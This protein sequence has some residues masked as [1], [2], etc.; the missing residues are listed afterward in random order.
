M[1]QVEEGGGEIMGDWAH[2]EREGESE[3][4]SCS[5]TLPSHKEKRSDEP[6]QISW[7]RFCD[8]VT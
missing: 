3:K 6:S 5:Q 4:W 2:R 1:K 7:A 8:S